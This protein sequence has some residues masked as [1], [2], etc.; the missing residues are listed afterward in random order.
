MHQE[1]IRSTLSWYNH[2]CH[3]TVFVVLDDTLP[4]MEGMVIAHVQLLLSF[5][6]SGI[7]HHC[8]LVNWLV[9]KDNKP[10]PDT[11]MW[12]VS[13]EKWNRVLTT[14][15]ID[16]KTIVRT[17]HLLP[18]FGQDMVPSDVHHYNSLDR[19]QSFF[20]NKYTDHHSQELLTDHYQ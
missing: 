14:Q 20:V 10:D 13:P 8:T 16:V 5:N 18:V 11:G 4:G 6:Y 15:V 12:I 1:Q 9:C 19:Y 7:D 17:A 2:P 3:D